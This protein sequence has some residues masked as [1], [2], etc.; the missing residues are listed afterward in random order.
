MRKS[1]V[2]KIKL[3]GS[4]ALLDEGGLRLRGVKDDCQVLGLESLVR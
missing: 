1:E 3:D 4:G 2:P